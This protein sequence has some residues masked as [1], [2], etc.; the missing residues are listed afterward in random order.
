MPDVDVSTDAQRV[1]LQ[2]EGAGD[3]G[4]GGDVAAP[5]G[6]VI[7]LSGVRGED[8]HHV[9]VVDVSAGPDAPTRR[10]GRFSTFGLARGEDDPDSSYRVDASSLVPQ[11]LDDGWDGQTLSVHVEP[12]PGR[13]DE[14][15]QRGSGV[16]IGQ[17]TLYV[18]R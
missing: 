10:A 1:D 15:S 18:R 14:A 7:E 8:P 6:L 9:Y 17:I 12:D 3:F 2:L 11:L 13:A 5:T 16:R 4:L